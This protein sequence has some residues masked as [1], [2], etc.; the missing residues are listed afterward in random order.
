MVNR[1]LFQR[2]LGEIAVD[3][4]DGIK[5]GLGKAAPGGSATFGLGVAVVDNSY[6]QQL[7]GPR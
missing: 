7:L 3:L 1:V 4:R 2:C 5:G 6:L